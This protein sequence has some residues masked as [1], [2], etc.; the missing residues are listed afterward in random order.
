MTLDL[1]TPDRGCL[2]FADI[3]GYTDY[4]AGTELMHAQDVLADLL[5]T[6][7]NS[8]EPTF[9]L[10]KLEGDAAFAYATS[11]SLNPSMVMDTV[12]S[13]YFSFRK[14]LRDITHSTT[15]ECNA[16]VMIP[17]L[18][19]KFFVHE[20]EYVVRKIAG[21]EELTGPDVI[22]VHRLAK[23][24]SGDVIGKP[25]FAVY[26]E[27]TLNKMSMD[28]SIL[29]FAP[30]TESFDGIGEVEVFVQDL[31]VRWAFEQE[32]HRDYVTSEQAILEV[33]IE[34]PAPPQV[35]WNHLTDPSKRIVWQSATTSLQSV[36]G[37]RAG[38]GSINHCMHGPDLIIEHV[39]DWRPFSYITC[40]YDIG[41]AIE[42][43]AWTTQLDETDEGTRAT[44]R[45]S[46]PGT[47]IWDAIGEQMIAQLDR[48]RAQ[49]SEMLLEAAQTEHT[50]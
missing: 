33:Q 16:C 50:G 44:I 23:G 40:R 12:E 21:S 32:R 29:G 34:T 10:S 25:A 4:L 17:S 31:S 30:H 14:R 43:W 24:T 46:D 28:P 22:L 47:E 42:K 8:I 45:L 15:C 49:L 38:A 5:E 36:T 7:V 18:D 27:T 9:K 1:G 3:T 26:T 19:L 48:D 37:G 35:V 11:E 41:E 6:L 13:A 39:S 2:L 20:G